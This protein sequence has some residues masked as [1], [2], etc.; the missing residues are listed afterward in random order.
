M[1][2]FQNSAETMGFHKIS[3]LVFY[4]VA[5]KHLLQK[6]VLLSTVSH[7]KN[8]KYKKPGKIKDFQ[9]LERLLSFPH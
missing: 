8:L 6:Y 1:D 2:S 5:V 4:A 9:L 3:T 7:R